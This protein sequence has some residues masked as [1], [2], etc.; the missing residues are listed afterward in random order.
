[1]AGTDQQLHVFM[2]DT[3]LGTLSRAHGG[4]LSFMYA[5]SYLSGQVR[6]PL[7]L[8]MPLD[9]RRYSHEKVNPW[10]W[11]LL[12][13]NE[14]VLARWA[15]RFQISPSNAFGF[16][17]G[18]GEDC[19]G[20]VRFI[21][22]E[23][24]DQA[25]R[26]GKTLITETEIERR[27]RELR[28]DPAMGREPD[29]RGQFSL[30]GA[31]SKTALQKRGEKWYIPWGREPT[32]H[33]L[34]P[35]RPDIAGHVE[36]EHFCLRLADALGLSV[37]KSEVIRF[38]QE[39]AI[40]V[41]RYDRVMI[42]RRLIR[43]HQEDACQALAVHPSRKYQSEGGPD[44]IKVMELM[45]R[46]NQPVEDRRRVMEAVIF[47]YLILGTDAHAKNFSLLLGVN[48]QVRLARLY[49]IASFLPYLSRRRDS[50]FAMKI[51]AYYKDAQIQPRH[52]DKMARSCEFPAQELRQMASGMASQLPNA[53]ERILDEM[54]RQ[55]ITHPVLDKLVG[56]LRRRAAEVAEDF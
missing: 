16:L 43:V 7:S 21:R 41:E 1:M 28:K 15:Q 26:E 27:L 3:P 24:L 17:Q 45:N 5:E 51:G 35:P 38:G 34:K 53:A 32:T 39:A 2:N 50:R 4:K 33:I 11:G 52:F 29:D 31:Q 47:N 36:N 55:G 49:D 25:D 8:T 10:I 56:L 42:Q 12:P 40:V 30:A 44:I 19:A 6:V 20:A 13:D 18:I 23:R 22:P 46:S 9:D 54:T 37:A 48:Q 14:L